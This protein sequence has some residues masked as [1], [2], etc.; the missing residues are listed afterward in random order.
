MRA[1]AFSVIFKMIFK[2]EEKIE[3]QELNYLVKIEICINFAV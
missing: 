1:G 3:N 2:K